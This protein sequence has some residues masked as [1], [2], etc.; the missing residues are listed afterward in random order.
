M[1]FIKVGLIREGKV[2]PDKRVPFTPIQVEEIGQRFSNVKVYCQHS[3]VRCFHDSEYEEVGAEILHDMNSCD[4]LMGIKEVPVSELIEGKTYLF[5]SHTIKRQPYNRKLL[6]EVLRKKI[7]LIDYEAL[8]D[9]Q[10]NRLVAFGRYAGI[11]GAYNGLWTYGK[12][13]GGFTLRRAF[14]CFDVNDLKLEL[15]K[16]VLPPIKLIL[17]G[18]GRVGRG[19][20]E[21]LD[22]AGIRKVSP[23]DFLSRQYNEPVYVQLSSAD[24]HRRKQGGHFNREEFHQYPERYLSHFTDFTRVADVLMAGAF[25]NPEAPVLFTKEDMQAKD[26][27]IKIIADITCDIEGSIPSTKKASSIPDPIYDYDPMTD[28]LQ[29]PLSSDRFIT[30]MAVDNLPCELP[31]S[32]SEEFG[33]DLIDRILKPLF[34]D[35]PEGI[36]ER[37]TIANDGALTE[38]FEYLSDYV[39]G[40]D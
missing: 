38:N 27:T 11:V 24:Y 23:A 7:R 17:T 30:V 6:Q 28:S 14:E 22:T 1:H 26:F 31:R 35:D 29:P 37:A 15:R 40:K 3:T 36:I 33:K 12:R 32:A 16:V 9:K 20:M 34:V 13:F 2:P 5:F 21:T 18:A 4:I 25:W 8:K 10:G 39:G 19:A